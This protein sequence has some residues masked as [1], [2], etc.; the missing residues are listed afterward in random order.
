MI[1]RNQFVILLIVIAFVSKVIGEF[2]HE[3][4]GHGLF[5]ILFGGKISSIHLS[6]LWPYEL[7]YIVYS[8][9]FKPIQ[10]IWITGG[11]ILV[12]FIVSGM[13]QALLL[14]NVV[15]DWR[16]SIPFFW[17]SFWTFLNP[18]GYLIIGGIKPFGDIASLI[19]DKVL[20]QQSSL[21]LGLV[22]FFIAF[23]SLSKILIKQFTSINIYQNIKE[24]R[25]SLILFWL[26]IPITTIITCL[27]MRLP[28]IYL[29]ILTILSL[30]P[31][32][33]SI[34]ASKFLITK[35]QYQ[36]SK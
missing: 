27:G 4:I 13:L 12:C 26:I 18:T 31:I 7:S 29:Q 23:F 25:V 33:I 32:P 35:N 22:I 2:V 36:Y 5:V 17:I 28:I 15:K 16:K 21:I 6:L 8:D 14:L 34:F 9:N 3:V 10:L 20:T 11:G 19:K 1:N 30:I 24:I